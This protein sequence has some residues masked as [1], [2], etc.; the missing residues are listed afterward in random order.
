MTIKIT[1]IILLALF[2]T[3]VFALFSLEIKDPDF[4]WH[5]KT[6]EYIVQTGSIPVTDPF[7]YTSTPKD[8][9]SPES[10]RMPFILAQ[11][12]LAQVLFYEIYTAFGF[13]GIIFLRALILTLVVVL[14]YRGIRREGLG[15]YLSLAMTIPVVLILYTFTGERPQLFSFL[16][17]FLIVFLLEGYRKNSLQS[18]RLSTQRSARGGKPAATQNYPPSAVYSLLPT[19]FIMFLWSNLHGGYIVGIGVLVCYLASEWVKYFWFSRKKIHTQNPNTPGNEERFRPSRN[20]RLI[21]E[22]AFTQDHINKYEKNIKIFKIKK[23][24]M[25]E[26]S[27]RHLTCFYNVLVLY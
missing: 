2:F 4:W 15:F 18:R 23:S 10:V 25:K 7:A 14:L 12:W 11:Y 9:L 27:I 26:Q 19:V 24:Q 20:D 5:L 3:F 17:S 6:G 21:D 22:S 8:P 16:F 13:Q 1:K